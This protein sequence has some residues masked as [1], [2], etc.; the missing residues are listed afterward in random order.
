MASWGMG[1]MVAPIAGPTLGGWDHDNW[2]WRWN[3]YINLPIGTIAF[4]DGLHFVHDPPF[5]HERRTRGGKVDYAGIM[6]LV[7]SVGLLQL[8]LDR[9]QRAD[10]FES[11]WVVLATGVSALSFMLL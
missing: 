6:L 8:V 5:M 11:S 1:L 10:W 4:P 7:L 2:N 3:F 9:G